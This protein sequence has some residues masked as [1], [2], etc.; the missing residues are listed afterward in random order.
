M[1]AR[2][3]KA[4]VYASLPVALLWA[5]FS[6]TGDKPKHGEPAAPGPTAA[7]KQP[8][9]AGVV[10]PADLDSKIHQPWGGDPFRS[11]GPSNGPERTV[12]G[13]ALALGGIVFHELHPMAFINGRT[14]QVG[15]TIGGATVVAIDRRSVTLEHQG[16][17]VKLSVNKG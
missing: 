6:F 12:T 11:T 16:R 15:D 7:S 1:R 8:S 14:V 10:R 2:F 13:L 17:Q 4:L 9:A 3:R 5:V